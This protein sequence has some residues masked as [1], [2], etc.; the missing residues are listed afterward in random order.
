MNSYSSL[1]FFPLCS[2][3][4]ISFKSTAKKVTYYTTNYLA[5]SF[6]TGADPLSPTLQIPL[7][8]TS[9]LALLIK[10]S[11]GRIKKLLQYNLLFHLFL[12][13]NDNEDIF[14]RMKVFFSDP[15]YIFDLHRLYMFYILLIIVHTETIELYQCKQS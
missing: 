14:I 12:I 1:D 8:E 9:Y 6:Q 2:P 13:G 11:T 3:Y 15:S 5:P 7:K 10:Q 4:N